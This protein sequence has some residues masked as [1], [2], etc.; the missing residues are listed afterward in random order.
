[1]CKALQAYEADRPERASSA[2]LRVLGP[3]SQLQF[4]HDVYSMQISAT[5]A[6]GIISN[7]SVELI[8]LAVKGASSSI[9]GAS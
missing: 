8:Q 7:A 4:Q 2:V 5:A 1:M 3:S 6:S 9:V